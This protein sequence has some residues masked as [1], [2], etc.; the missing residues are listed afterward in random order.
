M[1]ANPEEAE[2]LKLQI[3]KVNVPAA[4]AA[5][6][7]ANTSCLHVAVFKEVAATHLLTCMQAAGSISP[8]G[9]LFDE[10]QG[11]P[12]LHVPLCD[13]LRMRAGSKT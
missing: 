2:A 8:N 10:P 4:S 7:C 9:A 1:I 13:G 3:E 12:H 6:I 5:A 11:H